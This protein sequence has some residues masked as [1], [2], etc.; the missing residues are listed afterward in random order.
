[1]IWENIGLA[2]SSLKSNKM[3]TLL[4][5]LGIIIG[6]MSIIGIMVIGD[7]MTSSVSGQLSSLGTNNITLSVQERG[8]QADIRASVPGVM[9]RLGNIAGKRPESDDLITDQMI[10][11]MTEAFGDQIAGVS[12]SFSAGSAKA[13]DGDLYA[14]ISISGVNAN[15]GM[16]NNVTQLSGRFISESDVENISQSA[17]VSDK[18]VKN[19]FPDDE[20]PI[21]QTVKIYKPTAIELYTIIGVYQYEQMGFV[22]STASEKDTPTTCYIPVTTAKQDLLEK[23]YNY[24]TVIGA[25]GTDVNE[26]TGKLQSYFNQI[27]L[28]NEEWQVSA[29]NMSSMLDTVQSMMTTMSVAIAF[30]AGISLLVGGIGVMNIMLVSVTERTKEIGTRKALGAQNFHIQLQFVTEAMI[31]ALIGGIIGLVLGIVVGAFATRI[32]EVPLVI[33][34]VTTIGS[35]LFSMAIGIVFGLYPANKAAKL[36]PIDALRYE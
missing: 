26:L 20:N 33:S 36:D 15:F 23:N 1:M 2:V 4:T 30:I 9:D 19:M 13:Q 27:Y 10:A 21:G 3:R 24:I 14:N 31:V 17:V 7:A 5:M 25:V 32:F 11:D 28:G 8:R 35:V 6:I 18:F 34:P 12:I 29:S 16:A 22:G